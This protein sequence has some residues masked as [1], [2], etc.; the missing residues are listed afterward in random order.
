MKSEFNVERV[1][2]R[3]HLCIVDA[4]EELGQPLIEVRD[5][6]IYVS[7]PQYQ[8]VAVQ[9]AANEATSGTADSIGLSLPIEQAVSADQLRNLLDKAAGKKPPR[10]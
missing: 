5:G 4:P 3:V 9:P 2:D 7:L 1:C 8:P 6:S 10:K